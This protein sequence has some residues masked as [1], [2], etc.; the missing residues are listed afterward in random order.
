[1]TTDARHLL[2]EWAPQAAIWCGWP[3]LAE[4][5]GGDLDGPRAE[6]SAV[7]RA[8]ARHVPVRVA[9]GSDDAARTAAA[10]TD[11]CGAKI[12]RVPTGDIW[13]R[14]TG[15]IVTGQGALRLA[16][17]FRFN[18]WGGKYLM[19][20][21][22]A[23]A[24]AIAAHERLA[25]RAHDFVLE[26]GGIDVDGEGRLLTTRQCLLNPNRNPS[27]GAASI[28]A[29]LRNA[30]GVSDIIW[31]GDGLANDHTDGHVDNVARFVAPGHVVCQHPAGVDDPNTDV[32]VEIERTLASHGLVVST[33][34]SPGRILGEDGM[35]LPASHMNFTITNGAVLM[36]TYEDH[37]SAIA[38]AGLSR[39]FPGREV[40]GLPARAILAGGGSFHCMTREI[41][42]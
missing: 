41:P 14:D 3:R 30:F 11:G 37:Y 40:I 29:V 38:L 4:E 16:N 28:E 31:I 9:A 10:L 21:D 12:I 39:L 19:E 24:P 15:P 2:P 33:I 13:L 6:I 5:W 27:M 18:G 1:M 42:A 32:L 36:P 23:T 20:G 7:I 17:V 34:P 8:L 26:G 22:G 25:A 35:P